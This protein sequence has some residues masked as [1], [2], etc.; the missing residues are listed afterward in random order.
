[1]IANIYSLISRYVTLINIRSKDMV[2]RVLYII[3]LL[4]L[5]PSAISAQP[6]DKNIGHLVNPEMTRLPSNPFIGIKK[7]M[8]LAQKEKLG[9]PTTVIATIWN[10][11][12]AARVLSLYK[13]T[14]KG[15]IFCNPSNMNTGRQLQVNP[16]TAAELYWKTN[17]ELE[18]K[19]NRTLFRQIRLEGISKKTVALEQY[20]VELIK[21]NKKSRGH[22]LCYLLEPNWIQ[23]SLLWHKD[24]VLMY[25]DVEY[26]K[27]AGNKWTMDHIRTTNKLRNEELGP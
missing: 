23:F 16:N 9:E 6:V 14:D 20:K 19:L 2:Q 22:S 4:P 25:N 27:M 21:N 8:A 26:R 5:I 7:W 18:K 15:I 10:K 1:M 17:P 24:N 3:F 13:T 12:P 11:H